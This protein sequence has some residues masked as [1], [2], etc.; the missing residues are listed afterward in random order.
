MISKKIEIKSPVD[1]SVLGEVVNS[2]VRDIPSYV[3]KA[4]KAYN[5]WCFSAPHERSEVLRS[6]AKK[7]IL[8]LKELATLHTKESG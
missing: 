3:S 1:G 2:C 6:A 7:L 8:K 5:S 4:R